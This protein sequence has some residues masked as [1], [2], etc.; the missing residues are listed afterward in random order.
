[1]KKTYDPAEVI[2]NERTRYEDYEELLIRRD[3]LYKEAGSYLTVYT[4]EFGDLIMANFELK[5]DCIKKK[6]TISYCRRRINRGLPINATHMRKE[7]EQEM[8]LYYTQLKEM[9]DEHEAAKN[10][11]TA[12]AFRFSRVKKIYR[13]LAKQIHPDIYQKTMEDKTLKEL[14]TRIV[15]AYHKNDMEALEE[16]EV[17]VRK[18]LEDLG[19]EG[20]TPDYTDLEE[21]IER[22]EKQINE[23]LTTEPYTYGELLEDE[24][25]K[26]QLRERLKAEHDDYETY[27]AILQQTLDELLKEGGV[28]LVWTIN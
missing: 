25:Q 1:M 9:A 26:E 12:G 8:Q 15:T 19:D 22:V 18:A 16:L 13:R 2:D 11:K 4:A 5:I 14:W 24:E 3:L 28:E 23:I 21:R 6:K 10:A 20:F 7:I 27:A 17:L